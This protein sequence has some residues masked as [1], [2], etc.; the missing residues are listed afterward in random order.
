MPSSITI[1]GTRVHDVTTN[2]AVD[3]IEHWI[4]KPDGRLRFVVN[5]GFHGLW[6]GSQDESFRQLLNSADLFTPDG[7][8]PVLISRLKGRSLRGRARGYDI[9]REFF[10]R[11]TRRGYSSFFLGDTEET[12][13]SLRARLEQ[14]Y[15]GHRIAG[16]LSPPFRPLTTEEDAEIVERINSARPDILWVGLGLPK[17]ERWIAEHREVLRVPVA[18]GIGACFRFLAGTVAPAPDWIGAAGLEWL[19]R[20][21]HEPRKLWRR[22]LVEGPLFL[23]EVLKELSGVKRYP[24]PD[25]EESARG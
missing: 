4:H 16:T 9:L 21:I 2:E 24:D 3:L 17:Q 1:L 25:P 8:A 19:W 5:T 10:T 15:P 6:V 14:E 11:A 20:F 7:I 13:A 18:M 12:L 22:D 23:L